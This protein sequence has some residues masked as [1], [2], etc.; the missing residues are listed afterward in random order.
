L[1]VGGPRGGW[2]RPPQGK[3]LKIVRAAGYLE[4]LPAEFPFPDQDPRWRP[5]VR[6]ELAEE[7]VV[8]PFLELRDLEGD[9]Y[10]HAAVYLEHKASG[11]RGGKVLYCWFGLRYSAYAD[12]LL[13]AVFALAAEKV[14]R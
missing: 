13:A 3:T 9:S 14:E 10:S 6:A 1:A 5:L 7:D 12:D 2:E 4:N 11:P 8:V